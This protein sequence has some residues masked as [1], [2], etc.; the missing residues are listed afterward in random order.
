MDVPFLL[1]SAQ[2]IINTFRFIMQIIEVGN[3]TPNFIIP[4]MDRIGDRKSVV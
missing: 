3:Q 2:L 4:D 1:N